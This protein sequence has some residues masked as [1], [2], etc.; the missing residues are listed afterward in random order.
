MKTEGGNS[1]DF[2]KSWSSYIIRSVPKLI[3]LLSNVL[4]SYNNIIQIVKVQ[5]L[6]WSLTICQLC[7]LLFLCW[8]YLKQVRSSFS[9]LFD[10][11]V[12]FFFL[13]WNLHPHLLT[14]KT[15]YWYR[16]FLSYQ[17]KEFSGYSWIIEIAS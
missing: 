15:E 6:F 4:F 12:V 2:F 1:K 7:F 17:E 10:M 13:I 8:L 14:C 16:L 3:Y 5:S 11:A 9:V